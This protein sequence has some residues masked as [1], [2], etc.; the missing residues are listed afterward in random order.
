LRFSQFE[1]CCG[2]GKADEAA[3]TRAFLREF[4]PG[5]PLANV[6]EFFVK[7]GGR[8]FSLPDW[9]D[10]LICT[11]AHRMYPFLP[12]FSTW[13]AVIKFDKTTNTSVDVKLTAGM[14]GP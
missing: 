8:C 5:T 14:E 3:A 7:A 4:P 10:Q 2:F 13:S 6:V 11:Y 12:I 1:P 9:P